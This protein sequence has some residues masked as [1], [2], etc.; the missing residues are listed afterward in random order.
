MTAP[1]PQTPDLADALAIAGGLLLTAGAAAVHWPL[2]LLTAG[3]LLLL[4]ACLAAR[5]A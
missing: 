4:A 2:G 1:N 3:G 5:A